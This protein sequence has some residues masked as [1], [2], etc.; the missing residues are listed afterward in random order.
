[1][2]RFAVVSSSA[3]RGF[4]SRLTSNGAWHLQQQQQQQ[5]IRYK[6][7]QTQL[8]RLFKRNP[9]RRRVEARMGIN[10]EGT[11]APDPIYPPVI[12]E[13]RILPNGWCPPPGTD[14]AIPEYP[15]QVARTKNK[16]N[17]AVGFLPVYSEF[18]YVRFFVRSFV[19]L[20]C[21]NACFLHTIRVNDPSD[22][23]IIYLSLLF[24]S[25]RMG[26]G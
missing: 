4:S 14:V 10:R 22:T 1:M 7:S 24:F 23:E 2:N 25:E 11:P 8:K 26:R 13:P 21:N 9:A 17:D 15:F 12:L 3:S 20:S 5:S 6:H 19:Q 16:P 18:R